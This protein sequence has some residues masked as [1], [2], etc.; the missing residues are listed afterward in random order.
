MMRVSRETRRRLLTWP[1]GPTMLRIGAVE[2]LPVERG[3]DKPTTLAGT[4]ATL[5]REAQTDRSPVIRSA[6]CSPRYG[7]L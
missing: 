3:G 6:M 7:G 2:P 1:F 5:G 4:S